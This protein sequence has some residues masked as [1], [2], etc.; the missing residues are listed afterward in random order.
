MQSLESA[1]FA[2]WPCATS[3]DVD[4][5]QL[6]LDR[7]YTKRANSANATERSRALS[8]A[9]IDSMQRRFR[10]RGLVPT[11]RLTSFAGVTQSDAA[12]ERR[13][14]R[15]CDLSLVMTR[16]LA[17]AD[18]AAS[19]DT[20]DALHAQDA[21][22]WLQAFQSVTGRSGPDQAV[23]LEILRRILSPCAWSVQGP[24]DAPW[25]C[26]LGVLVDRHLGLFDIATRADRQRCG[27][28]RQLCGGLLAWGWRHGARTAFLQV[29]AINEGAIDL[30]R[31]LGFQVAYTYWYRVQPA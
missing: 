8:D 5:W 9:D 4:G 1:A 18:A 3:I 21:S 23:H 20:Q 14:Y 22:A 10:E 24:A 26:G 16:P 30:Y 28:A 12:L 25:C 2:A 11:F 13:G 31:S 15:R 19:D 29:L 6:R 27:L 17:A 7:G